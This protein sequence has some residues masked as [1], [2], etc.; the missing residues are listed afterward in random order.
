MPGTTGLSCR[1]VEAGITINGVPFSVV[2]EPWRSGGARERGMEVGPGMRRKG[3]LFIVVVENT[4][5]PDPDPEFA[6]PGGAGTFVGPGITRNGVPF[7]V[8]VSPVS[9]AGA[10][11][12]GIVVGPG[13]TRSVEPS[14][15]VV[16]N[17]ACPDPPAGAGAGIF[18]GPGTIKNGTPPIVDVTPVNP[19]GAFASGI[20]VGPGITST[21]EPSITLVGNIF[22]PP[23][24]PPPGAC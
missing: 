24:P 4:P 8:V 20:D 22:P 3:V 13:M 15:T 21:V 14:I 7:I 18:V 19:A 23:P 10:L 11:V 9:P 17:V 12:S 2:V 1:V 6:L 16:G 5:F